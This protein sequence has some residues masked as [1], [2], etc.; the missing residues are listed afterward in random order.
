MYKCV[1][2]I[3]LILLILVNLKKNIF[4]ENFNFQFKIDKPI[5]WNKLNFT[6]KSKIYGRQLNQNYSLYVDKLNV[7]NYIKNLNI[8]DLY[9]AKVY[10]ILDNNKDSLNLNDFPKNCVIKPNHG[11]ADIIII[12]NRIIKKRQARGEKF[13][14]IL[15]HDILW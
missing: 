15:G 14:S 4:K 7:K 3:F 10:A 11:W 6:D 2:L 8:K 9:T 5:Y 1:Y 13:E 12:K